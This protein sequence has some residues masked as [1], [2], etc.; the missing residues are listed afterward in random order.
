VNSRC[1]TQDEMLILAVIDRV[2]GIVR[3]KGLHLAHFIIEAKDDTNTVEAVVSYIV[4]DKT[5]LEKVPY[6]AVASF[7]T[8]AMDPLV[9]FIFN[10][11]TKLKHEKGD[12]KETLLYAVLETIDMGAKAYGVTLLVDFA[13][14][15]FPMLQSM[16]PFKT[17]LFLAAP[18]I[19]MVVWAATSISNIKHLLLHKAGESLSYNIVDTA[20]N[21]QIEKRKQDIKCISTCFLYFSPSLWHP[22]GK[23]CLY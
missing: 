7:V 17:D 13:Q 20:E 8:M 5:L 19:G 15:L 11:S 21:F 16:L 12:Y 3:C 1:G 10:N 4:T 23:G 22:P 2:D 6:L 18:A 9:E 14:C